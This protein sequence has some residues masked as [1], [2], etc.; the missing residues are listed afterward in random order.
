MGCINSNWNLIWKLNIIF[1][2]VFFLIFGEFFWETS[3]YSINALTLL[4]SVIFSCLIAPSR[5]PGWCLSQLRLESNCPHLAWWRIF[6]SPSASDKS[7]ARALSHSQIDRLQDPS[8]LRH[9]IHLI[10]VTSSS[11]ASKAYPSET[12]HLS[13]KSILV[14]LWHCCKNIVNL[15]FIWA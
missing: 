8:L 9:F 3:S 14:Q 12:L 11:F 13:S 15:H 6:H 7:Y 10:P 1:K 4:T 5:P 2:N